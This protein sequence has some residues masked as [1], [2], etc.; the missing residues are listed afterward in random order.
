MPVAESR[1]YG[2]VG[3]LENGN[4]VLRCV[5]K[6][7]ELKPSWRS[8]MEIT[9]QS[10]ALVFASSSARGTEFAMILASVTPNRYALMK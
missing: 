2:T 10:S 4:K 3:L 5:E 9:R 1:R 7:K 8:E 6:P